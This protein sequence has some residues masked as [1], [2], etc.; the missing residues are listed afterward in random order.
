MND[1]YSRAVKCV[2][3]VKRKHRNCKN[4]KIAILIKKKF[5]KLGL[6]KDLRLEL[7]ASEVSSRAL[8]FIE[9]GMK[10]VNPII[11]SA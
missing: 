5:I 6:P 3:H 1:T 4:M 8:W 11:Y 10:K 2:K 7:T 9:V